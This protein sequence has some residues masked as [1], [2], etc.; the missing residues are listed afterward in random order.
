[1]ADDNLSFWYATN[2][3]FAQ[4]KRIQDR[5]QFISGLEFFKILLNLMTLPNR[6]PFLMLFPDSI[7]I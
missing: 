4:E 3:L 1:M 5:N 2:L 6:P 7:Y